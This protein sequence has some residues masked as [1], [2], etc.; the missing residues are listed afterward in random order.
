MPSDSI[1]NHFPAALPRS[2]VVRA[3]ASGASGLGERLLTPIGALTLGLAACF[4]VLLA[5]KLI[6]AE[7]RSFAA[8]GAM[9]V[10]GLWLSTAGFRRDGMVFAISSTLCLLPVALIECG[11][12]ALDNAGLALLVETACVGALFAGS[13][14]RL[15]AEFMRRC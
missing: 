5:T 7:L 10:I 6:G 8:L 2:R 12:I 1:A 11:W 9:A 15:G 3:P 14:R 13:L 4:I